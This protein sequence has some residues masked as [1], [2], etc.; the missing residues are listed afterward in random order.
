MTS[1]GLPDRTDGHEAPWPRQPDY[2]PVDRQVIATKFLSIY[3]GASARAVMPRR[4]SCGGI[5]LG[6]HPP[7]QLVAKSLQDF[8][9]PGE[10]GEVGELVGIG[11]GVVELL[12]RMVL[13]RLHQTGG[14]GI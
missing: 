10:A 3:R 9:A 11:L 13:D 12:G 1:Q 7:A 6:D 5:S 14:R 4:L 2:S 8:L